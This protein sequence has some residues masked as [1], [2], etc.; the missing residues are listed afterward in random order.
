MVSNAVWNSAFVDDGHESYSYSE[1]RRQLRKYIQDNPHLT[2]KGK[3]STIR[4]EK[5]WL[6]AFWIV[7]C[8]NCLKQRLGRSLEMSDFKPSLPINN[9]IWLGY[10]L[11]LK[12]GAELGDKKDEGG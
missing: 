2:S 12:R 6:P 9:G 4:G 1:L 5:V 7:L 10:E 8:F 3:V 11:G